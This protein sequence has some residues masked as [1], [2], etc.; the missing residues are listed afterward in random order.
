MR[1]IKLFTYQTDKKFQ[2]VK[3]PVGQAVKTGLSTPG[4]AVTSASE[5]SMESN[6]AAAILI[7]NV[8]TY[9]DYV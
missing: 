2:S 3:T 9:E 7:T 8:Y 5:I 1:Y 4:L 6:L